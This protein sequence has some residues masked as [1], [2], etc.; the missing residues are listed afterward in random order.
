MKG[1]L[2]VNLGTPNSSHPK[3]V[4]KYLSQFLTDPRVIEIQSP[5]RQL[6]VRGLIVPRRYHSSAEMYK[7]VWTKEGS[8]L[9]SHSRRMGAALQKELGEN[10]RVH[11]AMR[12]QNPSLQK[13]LQEMKGYDSITI[14]PLFPQYAGATTGSVHEAVMKEVSQWKVIPELKFIQSYPVLKKMI[15]AFAARA[16]V[17]DLS[18]FDEVIMSFHGLPVT[19]DYDQ[20][21]SSECVKTAEAIALELNLPRYHLAFQSRLGNKPWLSPYT[22]EVIASLKGKKILVFCPAFVA[23]CLETLFEIGIE[24]AREGDV[25][26]VPSLNDHPLWI[27]G[28][29]ALI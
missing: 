6:L 20:R 27:Q 19:A 2:L 12:Y 24:Y 8:P 21:Y 9:L 17:F 28:L 25:T 4:K 3:D 18:S 13:T 1:I 10:Y 15:E 26:L 16:R 23:D 7:E 29:K 5:W 11:L 22:S 14:I